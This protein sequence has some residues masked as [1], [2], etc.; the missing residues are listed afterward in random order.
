MAR[1]GR[2]RLAFEQASVESQAVPTADD[3][4]MLEVKG[5]LVSA[6]ADLVPPRRY[7]AA[8]ERST[9]WPRRRLMRAPP[10]NRPDNPGTRHDDDDDQIQ[11]VLGDDRGPRR[12]SSAR[13]CQGLEDIAR[14]Q[15]PVPGGGTCIVQVLCPSLSGLDALAW[16][17]HHARGSVRSRLRHRYE[18]RWQ[19]LHAGG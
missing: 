2:I 19:G 18:A 5:V 9:S 11:H 4:I 7:L 6:T 8:I 13:H 17:W 14:C 1:Y 12:H 16:R 3:K 15:E 10:I